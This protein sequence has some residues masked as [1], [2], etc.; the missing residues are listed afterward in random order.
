MFLQGMEI[1]EH[2]RDIPQTSDPA[3]I[4][5]IYVDL[6]LQTLQKAGVISGP[7]PDA[8]PPATASHEAVPSSSV[9]AVNDNTASPATQQP[10]MS[11]AQPLQAG[12]EGR[13][14]TASSSAPTNTSPASSAG[15]LTSP[16]SQVSQ[17]HVC[18]ADAFPLN[19]SV[20]RSNL[21]YV[22]VCNTELTVHLTVV[23]V[24]QVPVK[25]S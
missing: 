6:N 16:G 20:D 23:E 10:S 15:S 5:R 3:P 22:H 13:Q 14:P 9:P 2:M 1:K 4:I 17:I 12:Q 19:Q 7:L 21:L 25:T 8:N 18:T 11:S 24:L